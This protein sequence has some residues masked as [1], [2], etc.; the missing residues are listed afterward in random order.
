VG[1]LRERLD[2]A[3]FDSYI[4]VDPVRAAIEAARHLSDE[5]TRFV[6]GDVFSPE[7]G[8]FDIVICNEVLYS[9]PE[10]PRQLTRL[11]QMLKPG[12]H[13]LTSDVRHPGDVGLRRLLDER[14]DLIDAVEVEND[15]RVGR[16][17]RRVA[18]YRRRD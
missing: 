5:R 6:I 1:L 14:L 15:T 8:Q 17:R 7:L 9:L 18:A 16:R 13:L 10:P 2:R 4:G 12:G 11:E 3:A